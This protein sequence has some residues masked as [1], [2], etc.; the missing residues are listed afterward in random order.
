[1]QDFVAPAI[2]AIVLMTIWA[3][4]GVA[5][6]LAGRE[7]RTAHGFRNAALGISNGLLRAAFVPPLLLWLTLYCQEYRIGLLHLAP[8]PAWAAMIGA[9][10]L[11]D[12]WHY[13]WHI[14]WHKV[15]FLWRFHTVHHHDPEVD[16]TTAL[17]FHAGEI[18]LSS[19]ALALA[20]PL[21]GL[22]LVQIAVFETIL[23]STAIFHHANLRMPLWMD[24]SLRTVVVTPRMHWVHHSR[25]E[26]ETDSNYSAIFSFWDRLFRTYRERDDI[27]AMELGLD[28]YT[29]HD[30]DTLAGIMTTPLGP[31]KSEAGRPTGAAAIDAKTEMEQLEQTGGRRSSAA[32]GTALATPST[33]PTRGRQLPL[34]LAVADKTAFKSGAPRGKRAAAAG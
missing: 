18:V 8:L 33:H 12:F 32:G 26:P 4:E 15:P 24:R 29:A 2:A 1:M 25:W 13:V 9:V 19:V 31:V 23:I 27:A 7:H 5:P 6:L 30:T 11:L 28:G 3:G 21:F 17:R 16:S 20:V 22:T 10:L 14:L 34:A